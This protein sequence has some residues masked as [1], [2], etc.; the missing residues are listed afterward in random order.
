MSQKYKI[1]GAFFICLLIF[2][3]YYTYHPKQIFSQASNEKN[4]KNGIKYNRWY[5]A[6]VLQYDKMK[7]CSDDL[8]K[9]PNFTEYLT[10][11]NCGHVTIDDKNKTTTREFT[12]IAEENHTVPISNTGG[13]FKAWT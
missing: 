9:R 11:F 6:S 2:F 8:S 7:N 4:N 3:S 12:L 5:T 1:F 13:K 10:Y